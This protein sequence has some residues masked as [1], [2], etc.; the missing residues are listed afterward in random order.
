VS[1]SCRSLLSDTSPSIIYLQFETGVLTQVSYAAESILCES[2]RELDRYPLCCGFQESIRNAERIRAETE[3]GTEAGDQLFTPALA[4]LFRLCPQP[5][6]LHLSHCLFESGLA[7]S[8][9]SCAEAPTYAP[10]LAALTALFLMLAAFKFVVTKGFPV[11][12]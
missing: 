7:S 2:Y 3:L 11:H 8:H 4:P 9:S 12:F 10:Q 1:F 5:T 6:C